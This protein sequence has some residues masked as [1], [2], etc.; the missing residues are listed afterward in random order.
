MKKLLI[1]LLLTSCASQPKIE[2]VTKVERIVVK[3]PAQL[4]EIPPYDMSLDV[5][6][7]TQRSIAQ[8]VLK[9]ETRMQQ[10]EDQIKALKKWSEEL[11]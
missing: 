8:W 4:L 1:L 10:L 11:K 5:D 6:H 3:P 7:A 9:T 2:T